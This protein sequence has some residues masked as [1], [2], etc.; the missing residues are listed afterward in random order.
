MR[1]LVFE[2]TMKV[3]MSE[4][5]FL[6]FDSNDK[7]IANVKDV[8]ELKALDDNLRKKYDVYE[9]YYKYIFINSKNDEV[10]LSTNAVIPEFL[11]PV[12]RE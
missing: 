2:S 12:M 9:N 1:E 6:T 10:I 5:G 4:D 7:I 8:F 11:K 3:Y